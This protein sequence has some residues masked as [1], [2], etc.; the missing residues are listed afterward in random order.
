MQ[1]YHIR[2]ISKHPKTF[3]STPPRKNTASRKIHHVFMVEIHLQPHGWLQPHGFFR[4]WQLKYFSCSSRKLGIFSN[5]THIFQMRLG[6]VQPPTGWGERS[7]GPPSILSK[8]T[9]RL[10]TCDHGKESLWRGGED[11]ETTGM[12]L[13]T[14]IVNMFFC[15]LF[16]G[17]GI[18]VECIC[19][20]CLFVYLISYIE[21]IDLDTDSSI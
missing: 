4:W 21:N 19:N 17:E 15:F 8:A 18:F 2:L 1:V 5:L 14:T 7:F 16:S 13:N 20:L 9:G 10:L 11:W 12:L 6:L 3:S